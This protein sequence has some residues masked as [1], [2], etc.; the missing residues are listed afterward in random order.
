VCLPARTLLV[1]LALA[2]LWLPRAALAHGGDEGLT[3]VRPVRVGLLEGVTQATC[4]I[5]GGAGLLIDLTTGNVLKELNPG[6]TLTTKALAVGVKAVDWAADGLRIEP[7]SGEARVTLAGK[8]YRG[9]IELHNWQGKLVIVNHC[10]LD[11]Y[12]YGVVPTE[13]PSGW[14]PEALKAQ[15]VAARTYAVRSMGQYEHGFYDLRPTVRDQVYGGAA[16]ERASTNDA[17]DATSGLILTYAGEP[18]TAYFH[19][20]SG[21]ETVDGSAMRGAKTAHPYLRAVPSREGEVKRWVVVVTP[22]ELRGTLI[23]KGYTCGEISDVRVCPHDPGQIEVVS[24]TGTLELPRNYLRSFLGS[25]RFR[26]ANF[27]VELDPAPTGDNDPLPSGTKIQFIGTGW[28]HGVGMSQ[29]GAK[30]FAEEG[31][32]YRQILLHYYRG[33]TLS[34]WYDISD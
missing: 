5:Q 12:L 15:A 10:T 32:N 20:A 18:I 22:Q 14:H 9:A 21:E 26:S 27:K 19:S 25:D 16:V 31:W 8:P 7:A 24:P 23:A 11:E 4:G 17:I 13:M 28:G 34:F 6:E 1:V 29:W 3:E 33:V 30:G 2:A